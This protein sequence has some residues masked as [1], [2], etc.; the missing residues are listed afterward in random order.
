MK[1]I[2]CLLLA[3]LMVLTAIPVFM[4]P[5][6]AA[7]ATVAEEE[8]I[9]IRF[10]L[11]DTRGTSAKNSENADAGT[12]IAERKCAPGFI[13]F[14]LPTEVECYTKGVNPQ[15]IIGWYAIDLDGNFVDVRAYNGTYQTSDLTFY[16]YLKSSGMGFNAPQNIPIVKGGSIVGMRSGWTVGEYTSAGFKA[17]KTIDAGSG[18]VYNASPWSNG[19]AYYASGG[20]GG[21]LV[22][23]PAASRVLA[24]SWT[25]V[26]DGTV[27]LTYDSF[28]FN[29]GLTIPANATAYLAVAVDN[30]VVW[31]TAIA[32]NDVVL[33]GFEAAGWYKIAAGNA[34]AGVGAQTVDIEGGSYTGL[35]VEAGQSVRFVIGYSAGQT[36]EL[37]PTV[38]YTEV[39][40]LSEN[41]ITKIPVYQSAAL[42]EA[43]LPLKAP[44]SDTDPELTYPG[45]WE[46]IT[47]KN[48][49]AITTA[50]PDLIEYYTV[51]SHGPTEFITSI[52]DYGGAS[53]APALM[54]NYAANSWG[55]LYDIAIKGGGSP[56]GFRYTVEH[57][58]Y[59]T[60]S[61]DQLLWQSL[62]AGAG[63]PERT[64]VA[65]FADGVMIWPAMGTVTEL[66]T[67]HQPF[68][69]QDYVSGTNT[70]AAANATIPEFYVQAGAKLDFIM[71]REGNGSIWNGCGNRMRPAITYKSAAFVTNF[72]VSGTLGT[73]LSL[74]FFANAGT[75]SFAEKV[76]TA[77]LDP[78]SLTLTVTPEEGSTLVGGSF[79]PTSS[80]INIDITDI[81][82]KQMTEKLDYA[83]TATAI[84]PSGDTEDVVLQEGSFSFAD[85]LVA[86]YN[87]PKSAQ[88]TRDLALATLRYGAAAQTRFNHKTNALAGAGIVGDPSFALDPVTDNYAQTG[89]GDYTFSAAT[90][91]LQDTVVLK[92]YVDA[93]AAPRADWEDLYLQAEGSDAKIPLVLREGCADGSRLK[94]LVGVPY[95]KFA[96][97]YSFTVYT[98]DGT[99]VSSTLTYSVASYAA[100]M[101]E[102]E[103][104]LTSLLDAIRTV[105]VAAEK[106]TLATAP[107]DDGNVVTKVVILSDAHIAESITNATGKLASALAQITDMG[108]VDA[109][110]LPG[111]MTN[112]GTDAE[113]KKLFE[114]FAE[115]GYIN[116]SEEDGPSAGNMPIG[117]VLGNHEFYRNGWDS[118]NSNTE[119]EKLDV[120]EVFDQLFSP[121]HDANLGFT[122]ANDGLD[123]TM[124]IDG[125]YFIGL[126]ERD[127]KGLY[128]EE[129]ESYLVQQV[130]AAAEADPTKPIF[131]YSH[132]GHGAIQ[133]STHM[134]VSDETAAELANY[135]QIV[136]ISGHTHY[137]SQNPYMIQQEEFT[138]LQV[139]TSGSKWWWVY[140]SG[141]TSPASYAYEAAQGVILSITD[142]NVVHAQRY[143]FGTGEE[144]GQDWVIDIPAILRSTDNFAYRVDDRAMQALAPT[145]AQE[146][147][148]SVTDIGEYSANITFP[149]A[150]IYDAVS[151]DVVQYY[152][153]VVADSEGEVV[154]S[155]RK[156]SE[157]YRGSRQNPTMTFSVSGLDDNS[158]YKVYVVAESIFGKTSAALTATFTTKEREIPTLDNLTTLID[159]DYSTKNAADA[160]NHTMYIRGPKDGAA[161]QMTTALDS[162][163]IKY[164]NNGNAVFDKSYCLGYAMTADD[165]TAMA[166]SLTIETVFT[167]TGDTSSNANWGWTG[168]VSNEESGGFTINHDTSSNKVLFTVN[169]TDGSQTKIYYKHTTNE[170]MHVVATTNNGL[171]CLYVNGELVGTA[172]ATGTAIKHASTKNLFIGANAWSSGNGQAPANCL[173]EYVNLFAEG[174]TSGQAELMYAN[175]SGTPLE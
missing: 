10:R 123:H 80:L 96:E 2:S 70:A 122:T 98:E 133:G 141:Y 53:S 4:L 174:V 104:E 25:A 44:S 159:I 84:L 76:D 16:P 170:E 69:A 29:K 116:Y 21:A 130:E 14:E 85:Y 37:R 126:S 131:I 125:T 88:P 127:N 71:Y 173:V 94:A 72:A 43:N 39:G 151:D 36:V 22:L 59:I 100:R 63:N 9:Y 89:S 97:D 105:G 38:S 129:V 108:D 111:D 34:E 62:A 65:I 150:H 13:E 158:E 83:L 165:I 90:L 107:T 156:L 60:P 23:S 30:K 42:D 143:D 87:S 66:D 49:A 144:I 106:Y 74:N 175:F 163:A 11:G 27:D 73:S 54:N 3:L 109:I 52:K 92:L 20:G 103:T 138:N 136:W 1:R 15:N 132:I 135:P 46:M 56:I 102:D 86:L 142:T 115:A 120:Y 171:A 57:A 81:H 110:I 117:F 157:Y 134:S 40:A 118:G 101:E 19:G 47:Y 95:T 166:T 155:Q 33:T 55:A 17:Y 139:P 5:S 58:G 146:D 82:A 168:V 161:S 50:T 77:Y 75:I 140:G 79:T 7:E 48:L 61:F 32:G 160:K 31:P 67:W 137:A 149:I 41:I 35:E 68:A 64:Y 51:S 147:A 162:T 172:Q 167:L 18:I 114:I 113:Y 119:E 8:A 91:L 164:D 99:P 93:T 148:I 45:A 28:I 12:L 124:I 169:Y 128:G 153:T 152:Y 26:A 6:V 154:F 121:I 112:N 78:D 24:I 145:F